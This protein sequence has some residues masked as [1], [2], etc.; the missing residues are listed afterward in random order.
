MTRTTVQRPMTAP[1]WSSACRTSRPT[2]LLPVRWMS[3]PGGTLCSARS[4][5]VTCPTFSAENQ[6]LVA[7]GDLPW[8]SLFQE[9]LAAI[10][11][12]MLGKK[13]ELTAVGDLVPGRGDGSCPAQEAQPACQHKG[14]SPGNGGTE[15]LE[16]KC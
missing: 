6:D 7:G 4:W 11:R 14:P 1:L 5:P 16:H 8:K 12:S 10:T 15:K 3:S 9:L 2:T 13:G